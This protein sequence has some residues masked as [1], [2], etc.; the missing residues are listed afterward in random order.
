MGRLDGL[1]R[2]VKAR[3]IFLH[4][5]LWSAEME[6]CAN[7]SRTLVVLAIAV[8]QTRWRGGA[9]NPPHPPSGIHVKLK[10]SRVNRL[11]S[12]SCRLLE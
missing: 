10:G 7:A 3:Y 8:E 4:K 9:T 5:N 11:L 1:L 2:P 6:V 12:T